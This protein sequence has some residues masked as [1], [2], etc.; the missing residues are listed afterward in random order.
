MYRVDLSTLMYRPVHVQAGYVG[1]KQN[2]TQ[3][4]GQFGINSYIIDLIASNIISYKQLGGVVHEIGH[5]L[6]LYHEQSRPDRDSYVIINLANVNTAAIS[7]F[8]KETTTTVETYGI[9]YDVGS[10][11]HYGS[12]V[13][14]YELVYHS[15]TCCC[16]L[17]SVSK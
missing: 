14:K 3:L 17:M 11:M 5:A 10:V 2:T 9:E 4:P 15:L 7:N 16:Y 1:D 12:G 6:G 8:D 13:Y